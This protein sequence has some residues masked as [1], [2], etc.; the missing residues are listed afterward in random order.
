ML[1]FMTSGIGVLLGALHGF[2]SVP[3]YTGFLEVSEYGIMRIVLITVT[4]L[5]GP[6]SLRMANGFSVFAAGLKDKGELSRQFLMGL[7]ATCA[8]MAFWTIVFVIVSPFVLPRQIH[9]YIWHILFMLYGY[10]LMNYSVTF[11]STF[12]MVLHSTLAQTGQIYSTMLLS[13]FF[14]YR[15]GRVESIFHAYMISCYSISIILTAIILKR[16][17]FSWKWNSPLLWK[18][19]KFSVPLIPI[20]LSGIV[21]QNLDQYFILYYMDEKAVAIYGVA[22]SLV[23]YMQSFIGAMLTT[24]NP[25]LFRLWGLK[26]YDRFRKYAWKANHFAVIFLGCSMLGLALYAPTL[27]D[28][29]ARKKELREASIYVIP[30]AAALSFAVIGNLILPFFYANKNST[31]SLYVHL[32]GAALNC[33]LN[34]LLIPGYGIMGAVWATIA[35]YFC[36]F[37]ALVFLSWKLM[38]IP[39][40]FSFLA[41]DAA[42]TVAFVFA[43]DKFV[44]HFPS[45]PI[46]IAWGVPFA[47]G[48]ILALIVVRCL[49]REDFDFIRGLF[50]KKSD[51]NYSSG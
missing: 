12:Q 16:T 28:I 7:A 9:P 46:R 23:F 50:R 5:Q 6:F 8:S 3:V 32:G 22:T 21:I 35:S 30:L 45:V 27:I 10:I 18:V 49:T 47:A 34:V 44:A 20:A 51:D 29:L 39:Y 24:Y 15:G 36:F 48:Y 42:V 13:I 26:E 38:R 40:D 11:I 43:A 17:G 25:T 33:A 19:V 41:R 37:A 31:V 4:L 1:R 14:L 2:I